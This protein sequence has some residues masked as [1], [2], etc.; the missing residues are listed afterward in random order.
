MKT[1]IIFLLLSFAALLRAQVPKLPEPVDGTYNQTFSFD[2]TGIVTG[3]LNND[4]NLDFVGRSDYVSGTI[5][6]EARL[7]NS[8]SVL[9]SFDTGVTS[10]VNDPLDTPILCWDF[11]E[12][13]DWEVYYQYRSG[14]IWRHRIVNGNTGATLVDAAHPKNWSATKSM[15]AVAY[16]SG[17]P[18]IVSCV[19][20]WSSYPYLTVLTTWNGSTWSLS[21][22]SGW[23]Y[24]NPGGP[25][26]MINTA[27][28]DADSSDDEILAGNVVF[29]GNGSERYRTADIVPNNQG[30]NADV[31]L[32]GFFDPQRPN[33]LVY[34]VGDAVGQNITAVWAKTGV[35]KWNYDME[36][37]FL[38]NFGVSGGWD[39]WHG[40]YLRQT[41]EG[42]TILAIDRA[43][44]SDHWALID[45]AR[46]A[47]V[48]SDT[49]N[50]TYCSG[51]KPLHWDCDNDAECGGVSYNDNFGRWDVG[52]D[53]C[54]EVWGFGADSTELQIA[55]NLSCTGCASKYDNQKYRQD[56]ARS[57][58][59]YAPYWSNAVVIVGTT[60]ENDPLNSP[61]ITNVAVSNI[62]LTSATITWD[63]HEGATSQ[64]VYGLT[65]A[66]GDTT[67]L[68]S[69]LDLFHTVNLT[70]LT[71]SATY[72]FKVISKDANNNSVSSTDYTFVCDCA[73]NL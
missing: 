23:P 51:A 25:H 17:R 30:G 20:F 26:D 39:H 3:D 21:E 44:N 63:T 10:S 69:D 60:A 50:P 5:R 65:T 38:D 43:S 48:A 22:M 27:D 28:V 53:G 36:E 41:S 4:G 47:I 67:A 32:I 55:F 42:A 33:K 29:N 19:D 14:G 1:R 52:A 35:L 64:V 70:G 12:D 16:I 2:L 11:D 71:T 62:G 66:Y 54:E 68:D 15:V 37:Y 13:G 72:H 58:S 46:G 56:V 34:I 73:G 59:G 57:A 6:I 8:A 7:Y 9:W 45:V 40:G 49:T 31:M 24:E 61:I 18:R